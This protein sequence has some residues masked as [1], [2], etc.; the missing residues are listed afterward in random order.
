MFK[1]WKTCKWCHCLLG[2]N[3]KICPHCKKVA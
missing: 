3:T 1:D 2:K